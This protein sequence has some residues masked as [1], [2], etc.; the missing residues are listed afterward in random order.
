MSAER[1]EIRAKIKAN[2]EEMARLTMENI[3]LQEQD[4]LLTDDVQQFKEEVEEWPHGDRRKKQM[5]K[6]LIGRVYWIEKFED[7]DTGQWVEIQRKKVVRIDGE[8]V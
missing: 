8:W 3:K 6:K 7:E 4:L 2:R 5:V 1:E